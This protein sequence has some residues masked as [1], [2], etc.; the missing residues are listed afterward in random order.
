[1]DVLYDSCAVARAKIVILYRY[2]NIICCIF[3][4]SGRCDN[5]RMKFFSKCSRRFS[6][7][8]DHAETVDTVGSNLIF[9]SN[10]MQSEFFDCICTNLSYPPGK[11]RCRIPVLPDTYSLVEPSSSMEHI[12]PFDSTP[13]S[14]PFLILM[15]PSVILPS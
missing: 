5:R 8:A 13:R 2:F 11:Y 4:V 6:C 9:K 14:F 12:I 7:D 1:M 3:T 15:P 10:I